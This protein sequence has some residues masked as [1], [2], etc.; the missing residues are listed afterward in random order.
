MS[1]A[2]LHVDILSSQ[3]SRDNVVNEQ[4]NYVDE[5]EVLRRA[6]F[7][8][9]LTYALRAANL[10]WNEISRLP[11]PYSAAQAGEGTSNGIAS[12]YWRQLRD[13]GVPSQCLP[14]DLRDELT[15]QR[16]SLPSQQQVD[17]E[18]ASKVRMATCM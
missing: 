15:P 1:A 8:Q 3:P 10:S 11:V 5:D 6:G 18:G 7:P 17:F 9:S 12:S 2:R 14:R 16:H 4:Q 13:A